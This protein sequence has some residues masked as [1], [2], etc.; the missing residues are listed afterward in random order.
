MI[1][2]VRPFRNSTV[3]R[4]ARRFS[5]SVVRSASVTWKSH[6]LP[7]TVMTGVSAERSDFMLS[8]NFV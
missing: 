8:Y 5:S 3:S 6:D 4:M 2:S 1:S 7:T